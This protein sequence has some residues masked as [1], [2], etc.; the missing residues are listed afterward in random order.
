MVVRMYDVEG[1]DTKVKMDS[2][3]RMENL[4]HMNIIEEDPKPAASMNVSKYGIETFS[5]QAKKK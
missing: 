1:K 2:F 4:Q 5:F 3:F